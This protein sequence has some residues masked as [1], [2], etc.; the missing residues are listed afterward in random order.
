MWLRVGRRRQ[1]DDRGRD[2]AEGSQL[3]AVPTPVGA[4]S[5]GAAVS[6]HRGA[7]AA[8]IVRPGS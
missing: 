8:A 2:V 5:F 3:L 6:L 1:H 4:S 7:L